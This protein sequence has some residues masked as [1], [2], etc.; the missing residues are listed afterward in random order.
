MSAEGSKTLNQKAI[1]FLKTFLRRNGI[2]NDYFGKKDL[3][4]VNVLDNILTEKDFEKVPLSRFRNK[5]SLFGAIA[6]SF[7]LYGENA[8]IHSMSNVVC[9]AAMF[10]SIQN[11]PSLIGPFENDDERNEAMDFLE[12]WREWYANADSQTRPSED[13]FL[14]RTDLICKMGKVR[15]FMMSFLSMTI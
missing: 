7:G 12:K 13:Q 5:D 15:Y 9:F 14:Q 8:N 3:E 6:I 10:N 4:V 1:K 11:D 2:T